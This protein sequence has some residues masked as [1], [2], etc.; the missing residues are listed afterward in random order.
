MRGTRKVKTDCIESQDVRTEFGSKFEGVL[1]T[2]EITLAC[3]VI[4]K[5][6]CD[7]FGGGG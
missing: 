5:L 7:E 2:E 4:L 6:D 1:K 3:G